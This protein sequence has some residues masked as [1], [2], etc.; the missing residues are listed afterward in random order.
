[1]SLCILFRHHSV[2]GCLR[3]DRSRKGPRL[4]TSPLSLSC[5]KLCS[6][7]LHATS[8]TVSWRQVRPARW[9]LGFEFVCYFR[10]MPQSEIAVPQVYPPHEPGERP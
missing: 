9:P 8:F 1:M 6:R 7:V 3:M 4:L 2:W 5:K 10:R